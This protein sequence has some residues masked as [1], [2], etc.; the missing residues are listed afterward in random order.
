VLLKCQSARSFCRKKYLHKKYEE[1]NKEWNKFL[2]DYSIAGTAVEIR[3]GEGEQMQTEGM[4]FEG[5]KM[6]G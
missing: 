1:A 6:V 3:W 5:G 4:E 2:R